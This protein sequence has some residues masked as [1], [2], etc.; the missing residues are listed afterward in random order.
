MTE[1]AIR[2]RGVVNRYDEITA[3]AH[4]SRGGDVRRDPRDLRPRPVVMSG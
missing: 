2:L 3:P 1:L 4:R